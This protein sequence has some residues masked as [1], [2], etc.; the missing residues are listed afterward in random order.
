MP[1]PETTTPVMLKIIEAAVN[2]KDGE[3]LWNILLDEEERRWRK[4]SPKITQ[5]EWLSRL[6]NIPDRVVKIQVACSVWWDYVEAWP[7]FDVYLA[8]WKQLPVANKEQTWKALVA[9]GYP[10]RMARKRIKVMT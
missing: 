6:E 9:L 1:T 10:E 5:E 4:E 3:L 2:Y 8:A 7:K